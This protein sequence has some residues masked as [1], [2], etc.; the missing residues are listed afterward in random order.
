MGLNTVCITPRHAEYQIIELLSVKVTN[1]VAH[2][3]RTEPATY[4]SQANF[5]RDR[6][7]DGV[8]TWLPPGVPRSLDSRSESAQSVSVYVR[9]RVRVR[10]SPNRGASPFCSMPF[11]Y[12][13]LERTIC[14]VHLITSDWSG[15][16]AE[17]PHKGRCLVEARENSMTLP[18]IYECNDPSRHGNVRHHLLRNSPLSDGERKRI[19]PN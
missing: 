4:G 9:L 13:I 2:I 16:S 8:G 10:V 15:T 12:N 18:N 19:P 11:H 1:E 6:R 14:L 5:E 17:L 7:W 3:W